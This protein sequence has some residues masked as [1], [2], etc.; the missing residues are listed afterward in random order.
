MVGVL[1]HNEQAG[2]IWGLGGREYDRISEAVADA[3]MHVVDRLVP[4]P[5]ERILDVATGTGWTARLL[6]SRGAV[7]TG[8]DI[9]AG[10]IAAAKALTPGIEFRVGDAEALSFETASF[11]A[12]VSTFGVMFAARPEAAAAELARVCRKGGRIGLV[13]WPPGGTVEGIFQIMWPYMPPPPVGAPPSPFEWGRPDRVRDLLGNAFDLRFETGTSTLRMPDGVAVWE[14]FVNGFG[15]IKSLAASCDDT[16]REQLER[17]FIAFHDRHA[18]RLSRD[19]RRSPI[20]STGI[21]IE[22]AGQGAG[23]GCGSAASR[24]SDRTTN[25]LIL[26][27]PQSGRSK[28]ARP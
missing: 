9:G 28:D 19:D 8:I 24:S 21:T 2:T 5:G 4:R 27:G 26:S 17:D 18:A 1:A 25:F 15:P 10:V 13:T 20:A 14:L 12:V 3:L 23:L 16:R 11:D 7:V 22:P 6:A